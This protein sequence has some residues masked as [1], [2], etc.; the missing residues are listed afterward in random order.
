MNISWSSG[1]NWWVLL[2]KHRKKHRLKI[3]LC[4]AA[5]LKPAHLLILF[6]Q[7]AHLK[8]WISWV[9]WVMHG[10]SING[11]RKPLPTEMR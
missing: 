10:I 1:V 3:I 4:C 9:L 6:S 8:V 11:I 5:L 7:K 2:S